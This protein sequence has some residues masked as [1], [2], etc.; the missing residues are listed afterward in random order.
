M[1]VEDFEKEMLTA[2]KALQKKAGKDDT[3]LE[4]QTNAFKALTVYYGILCKFRKPEDEGG[5]DTFEHFQDDI[6]RV[7]NEEAAPH[8]NGSRPSLRDRQRQR[9]AAPAA[10]NGAPTAGEPEPGSSH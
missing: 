7:V 2:A 8:G 3:P 4:E 6:H 9:G 1:S 5:D 10:A